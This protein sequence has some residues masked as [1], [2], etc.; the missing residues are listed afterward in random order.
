MRDELGRLLG[1]ARS[2]EIAG[3]EPGD[4]AGYTDGEQRG[5]QDSRSPRA[6]TRASALATRASALATRASALASRGSAPAGR[7][8]TLGT[9]A[10]V[11]ARRGN[12][13]GTRASVPGGRG[14]ALADRDYRAWRLDPRELGPRAAPALRSLRPPLEWL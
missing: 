14:S 5:R 10:S 2:S 3:E 7:G 4:P 6:A 11:P 8:N 12:T 9:R 1:E 13:L